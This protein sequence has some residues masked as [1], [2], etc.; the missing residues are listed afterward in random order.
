VR[1]FS[2][3][4]NAFF[5]SPRHLLTATNPPVPPCGS[6]LD[7]CEENASDDRPMTAVK[8]LP[9]NSLPLAA[10]RRL[11]DSHDRRILVRKKFELGF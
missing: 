5:G 10:Q 4:L 11:N 3:V 2:L 8:I 6:E 9:L 7:S 1:T